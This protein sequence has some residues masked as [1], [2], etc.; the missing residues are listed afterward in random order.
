MVFKGATGE[1]QIVLL[2]TM[3]SVIG[4]CHKLLDT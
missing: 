1:Y 3:L 4:Q 2:L